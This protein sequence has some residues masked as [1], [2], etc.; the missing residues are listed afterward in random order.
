MSGDHDDRNLAFLTFLS[1]FSVHFNEG[2]GIDQYTGM[3]RYLFSP[4]QVVRTWNVERSTV[5]A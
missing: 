5:R 3:L 4:R 1:L 2:L